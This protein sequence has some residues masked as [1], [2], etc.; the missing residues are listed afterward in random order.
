MFDF[1]VRF[2]HLL[3]LHSGRT[4][5]STV[6]VEGSVVEVPDGLSIRFSTCYLL[7]CFKAGI[8]HGEYAACRKALNLG[9]VK[10]VAEESILILCSGV[11]SAQISDKLVAAE[12]DRG[13]LPV[14]FAGLAVSEAVVLTAGKN[15]S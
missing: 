2:C 13:G 9:F 8:G 3:A 1:S 7:V 12:F 6:P 5:V 11:E 15:C 10:T 14:A 4:M